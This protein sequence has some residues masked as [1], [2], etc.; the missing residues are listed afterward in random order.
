MTAAARNSVVSSLLGAG[1]ALANV[2]GV[3]TLNKLI[4]IE[5]RMT[6]LEVSDRMR[7][8]KGKAILT[9]EQ[10]AAMPPAGACRS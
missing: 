7:A 4:D 2:W 6:S 10:R 1:V 5:H 8:Y 3:W 9:V